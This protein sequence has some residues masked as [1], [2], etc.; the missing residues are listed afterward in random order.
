MWCKEMAHYEIPL[1]EQDPA[2]GGDI[3]SHFI[4]DHQNQKCKPYGPTR[5]TQSK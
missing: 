5:K 3:Q 1:L 2:K 4:R